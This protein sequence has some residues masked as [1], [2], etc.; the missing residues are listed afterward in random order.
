[1]VSRVRTGDVVQDCSGLH[2]HL[3][4]GVGVGLIPH[5]TDSLITPVI[6][7]C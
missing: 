5:R 7:D 3:G 1:M 6:E 2:L 4:Y